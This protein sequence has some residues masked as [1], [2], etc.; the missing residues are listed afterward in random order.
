MCHFGPR[1]LQRPMSIHLP[2]PQP[3][4]RAG[5]PVNQLDD[6]PPRS[7]L[8]AGRERAAPDASAPGAQPPNNQPMTMRCTMPT[9]TPQSAQNRCGDIDGNHIALLSWVEQVAEDPGKGRCFPGSTSKAR[10]SA[11]VPMCS[12]SA[13]GANGG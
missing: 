3:G 9:E 2:T 12:T 10:S 7:R 4:Q 11:E 6:D 5:R 1:V 13:S 8:V